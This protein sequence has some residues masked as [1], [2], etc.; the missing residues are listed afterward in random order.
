MKLSVCM[1]VHNE[2]KQ[3]AECLSCLGFAD[4]IVIAL[5]KTTDGSKA[6]AEKF[7]AVI[8]EG[9]WPLE[10]ERR[11]A[12][13]DAATG[14]WILEVDCD[15]RIT[16]ELG[17]EIRRVID[18]S[19]SQLHCIPFDNYVG[20]RLV[21][22]GWG[23]YMGVQAK[24]A[25]FRKGAKTH[26]KNGRVTHPVPIL[27]GEFGHMLEHRIIHYIDKD[28]TDTIRRFNSYTTAGA[29]D[30]LAKGEIGSFGRNILRFFSR[31]YKSYIRRHGYREGDIGFFIG[32]L[33]G[34]YP[35][36]SYLKAKYRQ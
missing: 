19:S 28:L 34:L 25:L 18:T 8:I 26:E 31:F 5:D 29:A 16:S 14:D 6:I 30:L 20:K 1:Q 2:E 17:Q 21:R 12:A 36:V 10:G 33:A 15:E 24:I 3:L 9:N 7:N 23:A 22:Y 13:I 35:L 27:N 32:I 4:E 11:D